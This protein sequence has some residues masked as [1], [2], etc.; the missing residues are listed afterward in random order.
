MEETL[1]ILLV[2]D[3]DADAQLFRF[4]IVKHP[5]LE[6]FEIQTIHK[7]SIDKA[8]AWL[9]GSDTAPDLICLDLGVPGLGKENLKATIN[10][11]SR[12]VAKSAIIGLTGA[13]SSSLVWRALE[14]EIGSENVFG[15]KS[16][17]RDNQ[18]IL[19]AIQRIA[20]QRSSGSSRIIQMEMARLDE[21]FK[22]LEKDITEILQRLQKLD[23]AVFMGSGDGKES[24]SYMVFQLHSAFPSLAA[25]AE[26]SNLKTRLEAIENQQAEGNL[27]FKLKRFDFWLKIGGYGAIA[28]LAAVFVL[29]LGGEAATE[30]LR[31][32]VGS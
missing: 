24:L 14:S 9:E 27:Q 15:K 8:I 31:V 11:L 32:I 6:R 1:T 20:S 30:I 13:D 22:S 29:W 26:V 28:V 12:Y 4:Q 10:K 25:Q 17:S 21:R 5:I 7:H 19:E 2:E 18:D 16:V 3:S 23:Q